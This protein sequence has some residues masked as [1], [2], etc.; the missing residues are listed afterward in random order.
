[1]KPEDRYDA[2]SQYPATPWYRKLRNLL[3]GIGTAVGIVL[4]LLYPPGGVVRHAPPPPP[5]K[6]LCTAG[7]DTDCVGGRVMV[8][9]SPAAPA[10]R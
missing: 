10:S 9:V 6:A 5:D 3:L 7:Q 1:L 2:D 8:I 4:L